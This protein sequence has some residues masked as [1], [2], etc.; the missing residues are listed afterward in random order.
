MLVRV[1]LLFIVRFQQVSDIL[2][3]YQQC[4]SVPIENYFFLL[5][6]YLECGGKFTLPQGN[7]NS[8]NYPNNYDSKLKCEWLLQTEP[9]HS[10]LL[11]FTDFDIQSS[12]NCS[13][14]VLRIYDGM[15]IDANKVIFQSC[16]FM[17]SSNGTGFKNLPIKS[18]SNSM[19][20]VFESDDQF[21]SKGFA[22]QY[23]M[24]FDK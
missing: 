8:P 10:I 13:A 3:F 19:L 15:I 11:Q 4:Y 16:G 1:F 23:E 22:A 7:I 9:S 12:V 2:F 5:C 21:E 20:I 18:T 17:D 14:D 24:V 6:C